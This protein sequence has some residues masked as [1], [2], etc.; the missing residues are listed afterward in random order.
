MHPATMGAPGSRIVDEPAALVH[1]H[2]PADG[3]VRY[4]LWSWSEGISKAQ[5]SQWS[6][7][8]GHSGP[9]RRYVRS[10]C[11]GP[12]FPE[13]MIGDGARTLMA[14]AAPAPS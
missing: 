10:S 13:Y 1:H 7:T 6:G 5:V 4:M 8:S 14:L 12:F 2:V 9:E 3:N 11:R